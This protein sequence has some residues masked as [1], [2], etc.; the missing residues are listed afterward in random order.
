MKKQIRKGVFETNSSSTHAINIFRGYNPENIPESIVVRPGEFGWER[1]TYDD[2]D[3][4]LA[5]LY[6]WCLCRMSPEIAEAKIEKALKNVG[7]KEV[8]FEIGT[9][10]R[11]EGCIDHSEDLYN[12][13]LDTIFDE[14]FADFVFGHMSY[15]ETGND[16]D[17]SSVCE[18]GSADFSIYKG[19]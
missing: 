15:I 2:V 8:E 9:G 12:E 1:H 14:Y 13:D 17:D 3:S 7:V 6:T 10:W 19:N 11:E 16:N 4:K 18:D 5:Y